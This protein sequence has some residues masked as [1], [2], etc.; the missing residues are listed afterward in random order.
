LEGPDNDYRLL[1]NEV[2]RLM[3]AEQLF[4]FVTAAPV[5][6]PSG[7]TMPVAGTND[8]AE[9]TLRNPA[10][11][12]DTG[13]TNKAVRGA[14]RQTAITSALESLRHYLSSY[15]ALRQPTGPGAS[16]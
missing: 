3:L 10:S 8:E 16:V 6:T 13:R 11:A 5:T 1:C 9:R 12:R 4:V 15:A 2:M 7:Q 14:R